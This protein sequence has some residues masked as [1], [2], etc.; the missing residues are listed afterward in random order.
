MNEIEYKL[1]FDSLGNKR[2]YK[3]NKSR[4]LKIEDHNSWLENDL[5]NQWIYKDYR[6]YYIVISMY[7]KD[8]YSLTISGY[9][10]KTKYKKLEKAKL[11]SFKLCDKILK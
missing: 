10:H 1:N 9:K 3:L 11:A 7:N 8:E 6:S 2:R 5:K 4:R